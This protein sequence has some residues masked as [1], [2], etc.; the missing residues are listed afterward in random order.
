MPVSS[1]LK[2]SDPLIAATYLT[3]RHLF[4]VIDKA[5]EP[6]MYHAFRVSSYGRTMEEKIV[7]MLHD[8]VEDA[9]QSL[10]RANHLDENVEAVFAFLKTY[11]SDEVVDAVNAITRRE[12][13]T[14]RDFIRRVGKNDLATRVKLNDLRDNTD[15]RRTSTL[16]VKQS[17]LDRYAWAKSYLLTKDKQEGG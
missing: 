9:W 14:Y 10:V 8:T 6:L 3:T 15:P 11:F 17:L 1:D 16:V 5:G 4:G 13:E 2:H 12:G 7:G